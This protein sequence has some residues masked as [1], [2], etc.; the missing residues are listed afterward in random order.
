MQLFAC[1]EFYDVGSWSSHEPIYSIV[2]IVFEKMT[3]GDGVD[4]V[5][6]LAVEYHGQAGGTELFATLLADTPKED[7]IKLITEQFKGH[8]E[9]LHNVLSYLQLKSA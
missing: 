7:I 3:T 6:R 4:K 1:G 8:P 2:N 9:R 5:I